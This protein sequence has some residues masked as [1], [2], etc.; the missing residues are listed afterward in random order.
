[1]SRY[2]HHL[3]PCPCIKSYADRC[4]EYP[5]LMQCQ[6]GLWPFKSLLATAAAVDKHLELCNRYAENKFW[7]AHWRTEALLCLVYQ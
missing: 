4:I 3:G 5:T 2:M 1:M 7:L 6:V